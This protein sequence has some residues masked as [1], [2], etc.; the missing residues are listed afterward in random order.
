[1]KRRAWIGVAAIAALVGGGAAL[2]TWVYGDFKAPIFPPMDPVPEIGTLSAAACSACHSEIYA[3]W[4]KSGHARAAVDP[5][6][7]AE[8]AHQPAPFVCHRCHTPLV[9]QR[10]EL[11]YWMWAV[12]PTLVPA[13]EDNDRFDP[14][15]QQEGVTCVV[16]HQVDGAMAGPFDDA[17]GAPHPTFKSDLRA[18]DAC[19]RCHQFGFERIGKLHR[20]VIDT[21]TEWHEYRDGG[22]DK[23]CADCHMPEVAPRPAGQIGPTPGQLRPGSDHSLRGPF[24]AEFVKTG[25]VVED[26]QLR[27]SAESARASL[28]IFN[29][30]GHRLPTAE[31]E[32]AIEV[33]LSALDASGHELAQDNQRFERPVDVVKLRELGE[34][35]TLHVAERRAVELSLD[36]LPTETASVRI[37]VEFWLWDPEH[38]SAREAGLSAE[39]LVHRVA[40]Q[41]VAVGGQH[42]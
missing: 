35:T 4:K 15:L 6:Y 22:G 18:V 1:M 19:A 14:Q 27:A 17:A 40:E 8:L 28:T 29:G 2:N 32:R 11:A 24:D 42:G 33:R 39:E 36:S 16:C 5:L 30:T 41:T 31:P 9:E 25:V 10:E 3:E 37:V 23:R 38:P 7:Q 34:D 26:L 21:V 13:T 12:L 20:P